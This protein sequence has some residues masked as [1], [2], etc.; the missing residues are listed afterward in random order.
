MVTWADIKPL[1]RMAFGHGP[2]TAANLNSISLADLA[3]HTSWHFRSAGT[4]NKRK[5]AQASGLFARRHRDLR[6]YPGSGNF[7]CHKP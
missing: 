7:D 1:A 5:G 3:S 2:W 4:V 6:L